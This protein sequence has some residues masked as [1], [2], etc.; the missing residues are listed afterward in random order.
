MQDAAAER[1]LREKEI[2]RVMQV[3]SRR[4]K[5]NPVLIGEPGVGKTGVVEGL[6][7]VIVAGRHCHVV[8]RISMDLSTVDITALPQHAVRR[9][10]FATLIGGDI[11]VDDLA[12]WTGTIGYEVLTNLGARYH[13]VWT[14]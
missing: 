10:D 13:R 3:L 6:A 5:N 12:T 11:T 1:R 8:G 4:T 9:G 7:Q 14:Q 2:E